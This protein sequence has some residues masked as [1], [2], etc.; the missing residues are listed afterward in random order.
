MIGKQYIDELIEIEDTREILYN[1]I[2]KLIR[3]KRVKK[4]HKNKHGNIPL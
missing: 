3:C 4:F 2:T 1:A